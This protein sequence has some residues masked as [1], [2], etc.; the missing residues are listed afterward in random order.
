[1]IGSVQLNG[2]ELELG[3]VFAELTIRHG[4]GSVDDGPMASTATLTLLNPARELVS[5][6]HAGDTLDIYLEGGAPRFRGRVTDAT[7][8]DDGLKA[9]LTITAASSLSWLS[10]RTVGNSDWPLES[11]YS[12]LLRVL[13]DAGILLTWPE[14][15]GSWAAAGGDW[16]D[17]GTAGRATVD[18]LDDGPQIAARV[19]SGET[20]GGYLGGEFRE[21]EP[22][23]VANL[24]DGTVL[25]QQLTVRSTKATVEL[26]PA[27]VLF[28]PAWDQADEVENSL[29]LEYDDG[30]GTPASVSAENLSSIA[31]F[32]I[33][34]NSVSSALALEAEA[35][36][37]AGLRVNR[38][39]FPRWNAASVDLLE[40]EPAITIGTPVRLHE[41]PSWAP[42][43]A[44]IGIVEGWEDLIA[45]D[46]HGGLS[47]VMRL[48]LSDPVLSGG[49]GALWY[50]TAKTWAQA[51]PATWAN[52]SS[53][54]PA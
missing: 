2:A 14:V 13:E 20:F 6:F 18:N 48:A 28:P 47:W 54:V 4:R 37:R 7:V 15:G 50:T 36:E 27:L 9:G 43:S 52:P 16:V 45:P 32:E 8:T 40:L 46:G 49:F 51:P 21:S 33:R 22:A 31:R 12:R 41:L 19:S 53:L 17:Y 25:V 38:R 42:D 11:W 29:T 44:Y 35:S 5:A 24:P 26:E 1:M 34:P 3:E 39:G 23:T 30:S 10:R